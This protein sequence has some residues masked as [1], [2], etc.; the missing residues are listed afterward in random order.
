[1]RRAAPALGAAAAFAILVAALPS[2]LTPRVA[3]GSIR[4]A[5]VE[6]GSVA[7]VVEA[8][9]TVAP[10]SERVVASPIE[11][12]LLAALK[13]P[14]D[15]VE[16][17]DRLVELDDSAVRAELA[18]LDDRV[19][20]LR[21]E[22]EQAALALQREL[23][24]LRQRE[25]SRGLERDV[26][27]AKLARWERL[28]ADGL[29]SDEQMDERRLDVRRA[30]IDVAGLGGSLRSAERTGTARLLGLDLA[31]GQAERER[32]GQ[33]RLLEMA[34]ARAES[35]GVVTWVLDDAGVT[36][37]RGAPLARVARL[38][39]YRVEA[40]ASDIQSA[41]L[42]AGLPVSVRA[43]GL[44]IAGTVTAVSP[45]VEGGVMTFDVALDE[46]S[47]ERLRPALRVDVWVTTQ[48]RADVL[49]VER[50]TGTSGASQ[51]DVFVIEGDEARRRSVTFGLAG[52]DRIEVVAG[53]Q[54][55][56]QLIVSDTTTWRGADELRLEGQ[57]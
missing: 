39:S 23:E 19:A 40:R 44:R 45:A 26:A 9:G 17:G 6:R 54:E 53:L 43:A 48:E 14:G 50:P 5:H 4:V 30:E 27:K 33:A 1:M 36:V 51:A 34:S 52:P 47:H 2:L 35:L 20:T 57:R 32:D 22:R 10:A 37:A 56:E 15:R 28:H 21:L 8:S 31:I 25:E 46:P 29:A 41:R 24:D 3:R 49:R 16:A 7:V 13:R 18:R 11:S 42:H 38:D 55:G 12:R